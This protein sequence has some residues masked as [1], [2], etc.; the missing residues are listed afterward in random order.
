MIP[1]IVRDQNIRTPVSRVGNKTS[2]LHIICK[3]FPLRYNRFVDVFGGSGSVLLGKPEKDPF[4][5]YNDIDRNLV[6]LFQCMKTRTMA[7][8]RELGFCNLNSREDYEALV[9]F[10]KDEEFKDNYLD[11]EIELTRLMLPHEYAEKLIELRLSITHDYDVRKAAMYLKL[12]RYSYASSG[13]SFAS[14]P[15]DIRKLFPLIQQA[16]R[17]LTDVVIENQVFEKLIRHYDRK[18]TFFYLDPPYYSTEGMYPGGFGKDDHKRMRD[19]LNTIKGF[20]LISYNDCPET[21]GLY[22]DYDI[23]SFSRP[24]S[25]AQRYEAGKEFKELLIANYD[26]LERVNNQPKQLTLFDNEAEKFDYNKILRSVV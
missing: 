9:K 7:L 10:F 6:N 25:M 23:L 16:G 19:L 2:L 13:K 11:E 1:S 18:D 22:M 26:L 20:C 24:H 3:L 21:R 15:Y 14:Q 17:R 12:L 8:I 5:V 4:E